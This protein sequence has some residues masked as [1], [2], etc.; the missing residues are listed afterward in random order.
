MDSHENR[1]MLGLIAKHSYEQHQKVI[2]IGGDIL[3][4]LQDCG[5]G[6]YVVMYLGLGNTFNK[7]VKTSYYTVV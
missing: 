6:S 4:E 1:K 2:N 7:V 5:L 3:L